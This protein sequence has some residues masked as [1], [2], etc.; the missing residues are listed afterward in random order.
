MGYGFQGVLEA[1]TEQG[2]GAIGPAS[3]ALASLAPTWHASGQ[4]AR[5]LLS[6]VISSLA[7]MQPLQRLPLLSATLQGLPQVR[8]CRVFWKHPNIQLACH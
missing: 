5:S 2:G 8:D 6:L 1:A 3:A 7:S 4:P